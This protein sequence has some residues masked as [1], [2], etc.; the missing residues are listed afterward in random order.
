MR[1]TVNICC[2]DIV[3]SLGVFRRTSRGVYIVSACHHP[4]LQLHEDDE[5]DDGAVV[6]LF[7]VV[8]AHV[9]H[10]DNLYH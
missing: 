3:G 6:H 4:S 9:F 8:Y 7:V 5:D 1:F 2:I 10:P